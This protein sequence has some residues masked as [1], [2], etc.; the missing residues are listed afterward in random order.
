VPKR[1]PN[2]NPPTL[3]QQLSSSPLPYTSPPQKHF[4]LRG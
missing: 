2:R 4:R 3:F 1:C